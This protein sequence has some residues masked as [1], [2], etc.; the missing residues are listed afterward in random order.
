MVTNKMEKIMKKQFRIFIAVVALAV[1]GC[2]VEAARG[3]HVAPR[4]AAPAAVASTQ[5][6]VIQPV[7][8]SAPAGLKPV[9]VSRQTPSL[10]SRAKAWLSNN[11]KLAICLGA[12][13]VAA[14]AYAATGAVQAYNAKDGERFRAF[15]APTKTVSVWQ[16]LF[17]PVKLTEG[18]VKALQSDAAFNNMGTLEK[19]KSYRVNAAQRKAI[20]KLRAGVADTK[21]KTAAQEKQVEAADEAQRVAAATQKAIEDRIEKA[22][23]DLASYGSVCWFKE[24][25][26]RRTAL[27]KEILKL[28]LQLSELPKVRKQITGMGWCGAFRK[29]RAR[30]NELTEHKRELKKKM[31]ERACEGVTAEN[32]DDK[33]T[34][35]KATELLCNANRSTKRDLRAQLGKLHVLKARLPFVIPAAPAV[36][37]DTPAATPGPAAT[38]PA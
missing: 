9:V 10:L 25:Q 38:T 20:D 19:D 7:V 28:Q 29:A 24:A 2:S 33:I 4:Q 35:L 36:V 22:K 12:A 32:V 26:E 37:D 17:S 3:R 13:S 6:A 14:G 11:R 23:K 16:R 1:M 5:S 18:E 31:I 34:E 27:S 8:V 30:R 21:R 15:I